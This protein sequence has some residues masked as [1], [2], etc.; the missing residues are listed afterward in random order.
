MPPMKIYR[1]T[2]KFAPLSLI[3]GFC[4][5]GCAVGPDFKQPDVPD[6]KKFSEFPLS[7]ELTSAPN[8]VAGASQKFVE[9]YAVPSEWW[10][11]FRSSEL[12]S[13]VETSLR[14]N[15]N[16]G[17]A[18]ASLRV[19]QENANATF[20]N[21]FPSVDVGAGATRQSLPPA[22][23]GQTSGSTNT[24]TVYNA[25]VNVSY[26][27]DLFGGAKRQREGA[28]AQAE[29]Q[30][31]QLEGTYLSLTSNLVNAAIREAAQ[32]EQLDAT[33]EILKSQEN[34]ASLIKKQFDI[35]TVSKIDVSSQNTLVANSQ[36]QLYAYDKNLSVTRNMLTAYIGGYPGNTKVPQFKLSS[37]ELPSSIPTVIASNLVRQR[38]DIKAAEA[39]LKLANA[40]VGV[41]TANLLP[42]INITG[43][44]ATQALAS[45]MLFGPASALWT[46]GAGL[47]QPIFQGGQ[48]LAQRRG[49]KANYE[50][51][52]FNYEAVVINAF[53]EVANT[54]KALDI[55]SKTLL[56]ASEANKNAAMTLDLVKQQYQLGSTNYLAV[57][58]AQTQSQQARINLIQA[59]A[60]RYTNT[61]ALYAALGGGWWT[62]QGPAYL[63]KTSNLETQTTQPHNVNNEVK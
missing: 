53:N 27:L 31:Y 36:S 6:I 59:Q 55:S 14:N 17:A 62:R 10:K 42:Q 1:F 47:T 34:L 18:E 41:A 54:L 4:L 49:A 9:G 38:P 39:Q 3:L 2:P 32:R 40:Q 29:F 35:G 13:L 52:A 23:Y 60:D 28:K 7:K 51:A 25:S 16:L 33:Q 58:N 45:D 46:L 21:I 56:S 22:Y 26:K 8:E 15:P 48:L 30:A 37:L 61:V 12:N 19:A 44:Y 24:F 43:S 50:V 57:L 63:G 5:F 11:L 20:G